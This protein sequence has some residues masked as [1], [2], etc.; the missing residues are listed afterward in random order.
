MLE[1]LNVLEPAQYAGKANTRFNQDHNDLSHGFGNLACSRV[2]L[3]QSRQISPHSKL[4]S[5]HLET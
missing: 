4:W 3:F 2:F 1:Q 5:K